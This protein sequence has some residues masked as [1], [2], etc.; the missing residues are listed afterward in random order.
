[1]WK[2]GWYGPVCFGVLYRSQYWLFWG[3]NQF[4]GGGQI[5]ESLNIARL[6]FVFVV[7]WY[8]FSDGIMALL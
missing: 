3:E 6:A 8:G 4:I 7:L 2:S 5:W 1:M